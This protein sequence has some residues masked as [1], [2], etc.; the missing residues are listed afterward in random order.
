MIR[1]HEDD[2]D[3]RREANL[4]RQSAQIRAMEKQL[5]SPNDDENAAEPLIPRQYRRRAEDRSSSRSSEMKI[6]FGIVV[7][8]LGF[9]WNAATMVQRF[10]QTATELKDIR[11]AVQSNGLMAYQINELRSQT[12]ELEARLERLEDRSRVR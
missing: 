8:L 12:A 3:R 5:M 2:Q 9:V 6:W 11:I 7:A 4:A 1:L 10:D